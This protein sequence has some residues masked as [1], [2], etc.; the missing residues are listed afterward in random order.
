MEVKFETAASKFFAS[1]LQIFLILENQ[2]VRIG[3]TTRKW[4]IRNENV[5]VYT[6]CRSLKG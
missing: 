1:K 2:P 4:K 3:L 6:G 5:Y